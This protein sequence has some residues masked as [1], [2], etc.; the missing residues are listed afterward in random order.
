MKYLRIKL[1]V[2]I[3]FMFSFTYS[4]RAAVSSLKFSSVTPDRN[5]YVINP[6]ADMSGTQEDP[7]TL[8][9]YVTKDNASFELEISGYNYKENT[10][11]TLIWSPEGPSKTTIST[12]R[13]GVLKATGTFR[14]KNLSDRSELYSL[15]ILSEG[16]AVP[17]ATRYIRFIYQTSYNGNDLIPHKTIRIV[18]SPL[19][20]KVGTQL[21]IK[22]I[23]EPPLSNGELFNWGAKDSELASVAETHSET[24]G[25]ITARAVGTTTIR[26]TSYYR[27]T[28]TGVT[29]STLII[30]GDDPVTEKTIA[31][32]PSPITVKVGGT[33]RVTA[34]VTPPLA[35]GETLAA[36][37]DNPALTQFVDS[38]YKSYIVMKGLKEGQ[39]RAT[40]TVK[41]SNGKVV[42]TQTTQVTVSK[43]GTTPPVD[44]PITDP[45]I[46]IS[47]SSSTIKPGQRTVLTAKAVPELTNREFIRWESTDLNIAELLYEGGDRMKIA[48]RGKNIGTTTITATIID[49]NGSVI[50]K[51][52]HTLTVSD[53]PSTPNPDPGNPSPSDPGS[54]GD[55]GGGGSGSCNTGAGILLL[56]P[57]IVGVIRKR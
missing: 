14:I 26:G 33:V 7:D 9:F 42:A 38:D 45:R 15:K 46:S 47:P 16:D 43:E 20:M 5:I 56:L 6:I 41:N 57:V 13:W 36:T 17:V 48:I 1:L 53:D 4:A 27:R 50:G 32:S 40:V 2:A 39:S 54:D 35:S 52:T 24:D 10:P 51:T 28:N 23:V 25:K 49:T 3:V 22:A 11:Y 30:T 8:G 19:V 44:P 18:P 31:I 34:T 29:Y 55:G 21:N 12:D 37:M